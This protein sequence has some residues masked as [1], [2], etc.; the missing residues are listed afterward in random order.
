MAEELRVGHIDSTILKKQDVPTGWR[1]CG[2]PEVAGCCLEVLAGGLTFW[3]GRLL[4]S[5]LLGTLGIKAASTAWYQPCA[6]QP[7]PGMWLALQE[8]WPCLGSWGHAED[9]DST[10][11][12]Q[13]LR[14]ACCR[15]LTRWLSFHQAAA[16]VFWLLPSSLL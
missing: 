8:R 12:R 11:G 5:S 14:V 7:L 6:F 4:P 2:S 10:S 15:Y 3:G 13:T 1:R 16:H 9:F